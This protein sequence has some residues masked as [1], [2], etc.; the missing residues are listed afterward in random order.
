MRREWVITEEDE[1][2]DCGGKYEVHPTENDNGFAIVNGETGA[3][4]SEVA[5][6]DEAVAQ[7]TA[8]NAD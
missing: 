7:A 3:V 5:G 4:R 6:R 1:I 8:L 2:I